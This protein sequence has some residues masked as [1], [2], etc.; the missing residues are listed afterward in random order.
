MVPGT[1]PPPP[2]VPPLPWADPLPPP[3][4]REE[5]LRYDQHELFKTNRLAT[6]VSAASFLLAAGFWMITII[7]I[8]LAF[9]AGAM[10]TFELVTATSESKRTP[11]A[12]R[13]RYKLVGILE[14]VVGVLTFANFF[15]IVCGIVNLASLPDERLL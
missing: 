11:Q 8:P 9:M 6:Y 12:N 10:A 3:R 5:P 15:S 7:G 1:A 2:A 14:I 4:P 13:E